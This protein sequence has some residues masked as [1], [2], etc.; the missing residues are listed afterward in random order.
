MNTDESIPSR[1]RTYLY[2]LHT[3][4][5]AVSEEAALHIL[6]RSSPTALVLEGQQRNTH[7]KISPGK[8]INSDENTI[9][10]KQLNY[11]YDPSITEN[12][13]KLLFEFSTTSFSEYLIGMNK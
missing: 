6:G 5:G 9:N 7:H 12:K 2:E 3:T 13:S 4:V 10:S 8:K 1:T 11:N